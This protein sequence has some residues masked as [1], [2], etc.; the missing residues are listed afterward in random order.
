MTITARH[1]LAG[2]A[3][4]FIAPEAPPIPRQHPPLPRQGSGKGASAAA[5]QRAARKR[6]NLRAR[7]GKRGAR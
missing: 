3:G 6:R 2:L 1:L 7:A 4:A 5:H